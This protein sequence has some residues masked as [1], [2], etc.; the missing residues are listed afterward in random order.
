MAFDVFHVGAVDIE[1][2]I[3]RAPSDVNENPNHT[4]V[5]RHHAGRTAPIYSVMG[6][7][8]PGV[9][10][11]SPEIGTALGVLTKDG[12][13]LAASKL[14]YT[15][16]KPTKNSTGSDHLT[17]AIAG[18]IGVPKTLSWNGGV[19]PWLLGVELRPESADGLTAPFIY[20]T[21]ALPALALIPQTFCGGKFLVNGT[22]VDCLQNLTVDWGMVVD[23]ILHKGLPAPV[24]SGV[25]ETKPA[26]RLTNLDPTARSTF[27]AFGTRITSSV[28]YLRKNAAT[29]GTPHRVPDATAEHISLTF[30]GGLVAPAATV[31][32]EEGK[33]TQELNVVFDENATTDWVVV[34]LNVAI[35]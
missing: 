17:T 35:P 11:N 28:L 19:A 3:I 18:G 12:V 33:T 15:R 9:T 32:P 30:V 5:R 13:A 24:R 29:T 7:I 21:A 10:F 8:M 2:T 31:A 25:Q 6:S 23:Q 4:I 20:S 16:R 34:A 26:L 27:G 1:G 22:E 14:Y